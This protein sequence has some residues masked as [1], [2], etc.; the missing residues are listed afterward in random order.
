MA[1][2]KLTD[3]AR[4]FYSGSVELH[5]DQVTWAK[6]CFDTDFVMSTPT[7]ITLLSYKQ[8]DRAGM[9]PPR[10]LRADAVDCPKR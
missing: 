7:S 3:T 9:S 6:L 8:P 1:I 4:I 2:L 5:A 10:S